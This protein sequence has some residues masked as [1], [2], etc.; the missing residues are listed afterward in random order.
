MRITTLLGI[1]ALMLAVIVTVAPR[2]QVAD[3]ANV[4]SLE[5][6]AVKLAAH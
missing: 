5:T 6:S 2:I 3:E 1:M 4:A